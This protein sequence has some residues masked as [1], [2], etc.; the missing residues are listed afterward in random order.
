LATDQPGVCQGVPGQARQG[1]AEGTAVGGDRSVPSVV[2][3]SSSSSSF[4]PPCVLPSRFRLS[5]LPTRPNMPCSHTL[6]P[7]PPRHIETGAEFSPPDFELAYQKQHQLVTALHRYLQDAHGAPT[8][9][10]LPV[11]YQTSRDLRLTAE[12]V[13]SAFLLELSLSSRKAKADLTI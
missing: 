9:W 3:G 7:Q 1:T 2:S 13:R 4:S 10:A 6:A 8:G 11:M 5:S 12:Q